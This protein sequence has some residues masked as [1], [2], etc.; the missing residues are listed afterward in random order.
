MIIGIDPFYFQI[1]YLQRPGVSLPSKLSEAS[2]KL[3]RGTAMALRAF[4]FLLL[5]YVV[6]H[7]IF[8]FLLLRTRL[9]DMTGADFL[10]LLCRTLVATAGAAYFA[11]KGFRQPALP[12]RDRIW[13][14]RWTALAFGVITLIIGS[15][16]ITTLQGDGIIFALAYGIAT[17]ILWLLF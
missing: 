16:L 11:V 17:G 4:L 13:C 7:K 14:E 9:A 3:E 6:F 5:V 12:E 1:F 2:H 10:L 15:T 8:P